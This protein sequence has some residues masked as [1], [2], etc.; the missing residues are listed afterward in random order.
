VGG[1]KQ[2]FVWDVTSGNVIRKLRGH[3]NR[4]N[5]IKFNKEESVLMSGS[6]DAT[7]RIWDLLSY[8]K[9]EIQVIKGFKDSVT[10][11]LITQDQIIASYFDFA[12]IP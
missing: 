6:N 1:D 2:V 8:S 10:R 5:T 12:L 3:D 7:I 9:K 4:V 11:I